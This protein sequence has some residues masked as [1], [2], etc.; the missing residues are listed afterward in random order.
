MKEWR[1]LFQKNILAQGKDH[2]YK[3]DVRHLQ[4]TQDG[5]T[6]IV[7][8]DEEHRVVISLPE[9]NVNEMHCDCS[10]AKDTAACGHLAAVFYAIEELHGCMEKDSPVSC[11]DF[12]GQLSHII[13]AADEQEL[14][15]FIIK[16]AEND[17]MLRDKILLRFNEAIDLSMIDQLKADAESIVKEYE[18]QSGYVDYGDAWSLKEKITDFLNDTTAV[19]IEKNEFL[20]AF[21]L[22]N[23]IVLLLADLEMDDSDG[24]MGMLGDLCYQKW[25][26]MMKKCSHEDKQSMSSWFNAHDPFTEDGNGTASIIESFRI[27]ELREELKL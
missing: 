2:F 22:V 19:L 5:Y 15:A 6:A 7:E 18:D 23:H 21:E 4:K 11:L 16:Q 10:Y 25:K 1:S 24:I 9:G 3:D 20:F 14:R 12:T 13:A 17:R 27:H 26:E 8:D